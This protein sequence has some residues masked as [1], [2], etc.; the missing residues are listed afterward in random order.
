MTSS[1]TQVLTQLLDVVKLHFDVNDN[2]SLQALIYLLYYH[3]VTQKLAEDDVNFLIDTIQN[4]II[5]RETTH[6]FEC[7]SCV[8]PDEVRFKILGFD[9]PKDVAGPD[10]VYYPQMPNGDQKDVGRSFLPFSVAKMLNL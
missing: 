7:Q 3:L 9:P 10:P 8:A 1:E 4:K 2:E 6:T 5:H